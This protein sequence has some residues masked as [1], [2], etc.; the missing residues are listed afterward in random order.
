MNVLLLRCLF[1]L[2][3]IFAAIRKSVFIAVII[4][5]RWGTVD[6]GDPIKACPKMESTCSP[7][8]CVITLSFIPPLSACLDMT[9]LLISIQ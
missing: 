7:L 9:G 6:S 3:F 1:I 4:R 2:W 8:V 5:L